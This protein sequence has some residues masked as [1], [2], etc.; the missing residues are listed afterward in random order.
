M[1]K[2]SLFLAALS[3]LLVSGSLAFAYPRYV[4][5]ATKV[6]DDGAA[7]QDSALIGE[8]KNGFLRGFPSPS[9]QALSREFGDYFGDA[10]WWNYDEYNVVMAGV[11]YA[12]GSKSRI[13]VSFYKEGQEPIWVSYV[14]IDG[15]IVYR[16]NEKYNR[17]D[18]EGLLHEI[19]A[20]H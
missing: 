15:D 9:Y 19:Y 11:T 12:N 14:Q 10:R 8:F 18:L 13:R 4:A 20:L 3:I 17:L 2:V 6:F 16:W 1:K 7:P 5:P